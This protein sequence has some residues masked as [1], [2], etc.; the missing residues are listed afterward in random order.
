MKNLKKIENN[1][2]NNKLQGSSQV[3]LY[4]GIHYEKGFTP[5]ESVTGMTYCN[6]AQ[7]EK[8]IKFLHTHFG[9]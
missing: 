2:Q 9:V 7:H 3:E 1:K 5:F 4:G 8:E 6:D